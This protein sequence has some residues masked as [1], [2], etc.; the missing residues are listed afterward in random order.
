MTSF[1]ATRLG[2][3]QFW[4]E[5][6]TIVVLITFVIFAA[7][8]SQGVFLRPTNL[9]TVLYQASIVGVLVLGQT[10]VVIAGGIDLS[11]VA[12][13]VFSAVVMGGAGSE[14]QSMMMLGGLPYIGFLPAIFAGFGAAAFAGFINGLIITRLHIPAFITTLATALLF[15]GIVLL[16][17]GGSP[18][19]YP[20]PFFTRFG[21][22]KVLGIQSPILVFVGLAL[23]YWWVLNQTSYGKKLYAIGGS[24]RAAVYS[25]ISVNNVR[26]LV[27][28]L[29]GLTAGLA[30]FLFLSRT[31]YVSYVSGGELLMSTIAAMV[32]GGVSLAGG[33]GGVKH[34][35]SGVL[36]LA[37]LSNLMNIMLISPHIQNAVNG[38]V[39]LLA[40]AIYGQLGSRS[41]S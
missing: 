3:G 5:N 34:A 40:V 41:G 36:L 8:V 12:I 6:G 27:Y 32:M 26:L 33:V 7:L 10:L 24:E 22:S 2:S 29:S 13:L 15:S 11:V 30:G 9:S 19:Y 38:G 28:T 16:V 25:G 39:I 4:K 17:T 14:R 37:S 35:V 18:I 31:G 23:V 21:E 20:D 1:V